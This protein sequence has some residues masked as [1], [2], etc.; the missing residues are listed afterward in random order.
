MGRQCFSRNTYCSRDIDPRR[1]FP[2]AE[3]NAEKSISVHDP[4]HSVCCHDADQY[5]RLELLLDLPDADRRGNQ[6]GGLSS[7]WA[8]AKGRR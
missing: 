1:S 8:A 2:N 4:D 7:V 6:S 5:F 3:E